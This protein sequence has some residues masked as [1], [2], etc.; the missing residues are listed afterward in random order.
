MIRLLTR[1]L[2]SINSQLQSRL[3]ELS[4]A[5]LEDLGEVLLDFATEADLMNWLNTIEN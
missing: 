1:Q 5:Q 3:Q 2:G 4:L